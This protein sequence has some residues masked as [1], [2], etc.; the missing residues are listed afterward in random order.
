MKELLTLFQFNLRNLLLNLNPKKVN[1]RAFAKELSIKM[2]ITREAE[3]LQIS[4]QDSDPLKPK[5]VYLQLPFREKSI[6]GYS[7]FSD[8]KNLEIGKKVILNV[9]Y[10]Y[11]GEG[12]LVC[13]QE[14]SI[15]S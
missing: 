15:V 14:Y 12:L 1:E 5:C 13:D 11:P 3:V 2:S 8:T 6:V 4:M 10:Y 9:T 7:F